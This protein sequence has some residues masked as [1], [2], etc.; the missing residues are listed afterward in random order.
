MKLTVRSNIRDT[1]R[2]LDKLQRQAVPAAAARALN[3]TATQARNQASREIKKKYAIGSRLLKRRI[4]ITSRADTFT[5]RAVVTAEG[6]PFPLLAFNPK[7]VKGRKQKGTR[8]RK[9]GGVKVTIKRGERKLIRGAFVAQM[10]SGHR[11]VFARGQYRNGR[12]VPSA[13]RLPITELFTLGVPQGFSD[14]EVEGAIV[15][16]VREKFPGILDHE[17]TFEIRR[18][19]LA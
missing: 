6:K 19:G 4:R 9:G 7:Q 16:L 11:G 2:Q 18:R 10:K 13:G 12:L 5:L 14:A 17:L 1:M 15:R 8:A 3:K